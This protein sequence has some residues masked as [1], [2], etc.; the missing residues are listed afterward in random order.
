VSG[1]ADIT[2]RQLVE[3]MAEGVLLTDVDGTIR[4]VNPAFCRVTGYAPEEVV[5][6]NP[7]LLQSGWQNP[8][9]YRD[10][11]EQLKRTGRWAG[12]IWNRRKDGEIYPEWLSVS[13]GRDPAGEVVFYLGVF[14]DIT[15]RKQSEERLERMAQYDPLTGLPNRLLLR[16]RL[17]QLLARARREGGR[18]A[19]MFLDLDGFKAWNDAY[20]H[21][22]GDHVLFRAA[23]RMSESLRKSDTLARVGGDEFVLLL[24]GADREAAAVMAGAVIGS[25]SRPLV[26]DGRDVRVGASIG[27]AV[28]PE[29]NL[30]VDNLLRLADEAMYAAKSRGGNGFAFSTP[31]RAP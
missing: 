20:G 24:G 7:R 25:L 13:A 19:V 6:K 21:A 16:D 8:A 27:I 28:Y 11:W 5:G 1:E 2:V 4:L 15:G 14:T 22:F 18:V 17:A 12:E 29:D 30:D 10:M 23:Q 31:G 3:A 9:F 26:V